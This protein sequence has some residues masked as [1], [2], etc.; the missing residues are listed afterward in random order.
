MKKKEYHLIPEE[1]KKCIWMTIGLISYKL[2]TNDYYC[3]ECVFDQVMRNEIAASNS[4]AVSSAAA[5]ILKKEPLPPAET[6]LFYHRYHCWAKVED[7]DEVRIG[8]DGILA[9]LFSRIKTIALPQE[10][11]IATQG[12]C[13]AHIMQERHI[14]QIISPLSG[15]IQNVN[16]LLKKNPQLLI[17]DPWDKGWLATIRPANLE[18]DLKSL[19]FGKKAMDWY[20]AKQQ[21]IAEAGVVMLGPDKK[22]LGRTLQDGGEQIAGVAD[23]LSSEQFER[24]I[25]SLYRNEDPAA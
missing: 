4:M 23:M 6:A 3:E 8:L 11:E 14:L 12:Q 19:M 18:H 21:V 15:T 7:P 25:E 24:I 13:F 22:S 2:C 16:Q 5:S 10:G 1:E 9:R 17:R 20:Q